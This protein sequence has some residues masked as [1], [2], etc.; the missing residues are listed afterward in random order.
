MLHIALISQLSPEAQQAFYV[1]LFMVIAMLII[2]FVVAVIPP[3]G[4]S[5]YGLLFLIFIMPLCMADLIGAQALMLAYL[6]IT[7]AGIIYIWC[8]CL[9]KRSRQQL[10]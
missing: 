10:C 5:G 1:C 9:R 2:E 4:R 7:C 6:A 8:L 3:R